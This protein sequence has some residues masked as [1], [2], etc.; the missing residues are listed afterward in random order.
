MIAGDQAIVKR[1]LTPKKAVQIMACEWN[2]DWFA[3]GRV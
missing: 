1:T 3:L 2:E